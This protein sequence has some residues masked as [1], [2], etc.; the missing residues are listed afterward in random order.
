MKQA[1]LVK[2][3]PENQEAM[4]TGEKD[5][6]KNTATGASNL[7]NSDDSSPSPLTTTG[8]QHGKNG[9]SNGNGKSTKGDSSKSAGRREE[10]QKETPLLEKFF[11]DQLKDMYYA[12]QQLTKAIP[13]M[14]EASTSEELKEAF[15]DHL[16]QTQKHVKRLEKVFKLLGKEAE[17]KKCE[18]IEGLVKE[19]NTII[20]ETKA[21]SAT[22]DAALIIAAQKVEHYEIASY[23][24]LVQ[25]ALTMNL[26]EVSDILDTTL[27]EEEDTDQLLTD[28]A[29]N[30]I[31][32]EAEAEAEYSWSTSTEV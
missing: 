10:A 14:E 15:N 20:S 30:S 9:H 13:K 1:E 18:A 28:I 12:E 3:N 16:H 7:S 26:D 22:R 6:D 32:M 4:E 11:T 17:G 25:L 8:D 21:G 19:A 29:E 27:M 31:N 2:D 24:G 5:Q 23:G